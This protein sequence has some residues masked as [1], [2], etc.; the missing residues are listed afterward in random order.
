MR[1]EAMAA[2]DVL[3]GEWRLIL[4]DAFFLEE[5]EVRGSA[6][7][8]WVGEAFVLLTVELGGGGPQSF[9]LGRSDANEAYAALYHDERGVNR[10]FVMEFGAGAWTLHREDPDFHQ[11]WIS[12]VSPDRIAGRW[13]ASEN[14]GA[15]WRKDFDLTFDRVR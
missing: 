12:M 7:G 11:R 3:V 1:S 14:A 4:S 6:R 13:E 15:T 2:L 5:D 8:E 9:V 10:L